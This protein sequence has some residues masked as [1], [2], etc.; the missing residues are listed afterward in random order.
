MISISFGGKEII[1]R[2]LCGGRLLGE[3]VFKRLHNI[4]RKVIATE[5]KPAFDLITTSAGSPGSSRFRSL[6]WKDTE[7]LFEKRQLVPALQRLLI[8]CQVVN[9]TQMPN[10]FLIVVLAQFPFLINYV[11]FF[12]R[13]EL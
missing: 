7:L 5:L 9:F 12:F 8:S 13:Y 3:A 1:S 11:P 4:H 6:H 10:Y 2:K